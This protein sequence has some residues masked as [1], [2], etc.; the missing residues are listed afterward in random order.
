MKYMTS[1]PQPPLHRRGG[2][3]LT[4]DCAFIGRSPLSCGEGL[5]ERLSINNSKYFVIVI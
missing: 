3:A 2:G 5:G 1:P 4:K